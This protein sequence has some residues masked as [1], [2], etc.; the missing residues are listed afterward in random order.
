MFYFLILEQH[1]L[2]FFSTKV[3]LIQ[4]ASVP[5]QMMCD[6]LIY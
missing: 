5:A 3:L 4:N 1:N 6:E 2:P